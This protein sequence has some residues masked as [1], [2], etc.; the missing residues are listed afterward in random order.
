LG[1]R[2]S[3]EKSAETK[4]KAPEI[5]VGALLERLAPNNSKKSSPVKFYGPAL[6]VPA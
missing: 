2:Q 4:E 1:E 3:E 6:K 5:K